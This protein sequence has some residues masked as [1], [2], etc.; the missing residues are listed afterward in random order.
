LIRFVAPILR[1]VQLFIATARLVLLPR[2]PTVRFVREAAVPLTLHDFKLG[3]MFVKG[4]RDSA[5]ESLMRGIVQGFAKPV[6]VD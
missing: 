4:E 6:K 1:K 3:K 2:N 5:D